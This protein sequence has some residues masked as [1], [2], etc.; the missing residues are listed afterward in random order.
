M[1]PAIISWNDKW[2]A[3]RKTQ[4]NVRLCGSLSVATQKLDIE[5]YASFNAVSKSSFYKKV[6]NDITL[7]TKGTALL[8]GVTNPIR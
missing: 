8:E 4:Q 7:T 2:F 6:Q 1:H 5:V 3:L